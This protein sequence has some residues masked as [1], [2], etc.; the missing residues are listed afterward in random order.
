MLRALEQGE[1]TPLGS[2]RAPERVDVR[3]ICATNRDLAAMVRE[4]QFRDDLYYRVGVVAIELPPL[5]TYKDNLEILAQVFVQQAAERHS[6][7]V[8]RISRAALSLLFAYD[9]P[10]NMRE[11]KNAMEHAV[12]LASGEELGAEHLPRSIREK[13][14]SAHAPT[15]VTPAKKPVATL[16]ELR[17]TWLAPH[18][19]AYLQEL[20][21]SSNGEVSAAA[22][23]AGVTRATLYRLMNKHGITLR[24]QAM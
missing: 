15:T 24:R 19:R 17:E 21:A 6:R 13:P 14:A 23:R 16:A 22:E 9:F 10:G 1:V 3:V 2:N 5:R 8:S 18:E 12:I 7:P 11:L 4:R 20:L